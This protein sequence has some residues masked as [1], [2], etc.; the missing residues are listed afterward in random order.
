VD[1]DKKNPGSRAALR[2]NGRPY[3]KT[4]TKRVENLV[5]VVVNSLGKHKIL[6]S[7]CNSIKRETKKKKVG[8]MREIHTHIYIYIN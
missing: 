4:K 3:Q 8:M 5:Q 6:R 1:T 2:K 7:N